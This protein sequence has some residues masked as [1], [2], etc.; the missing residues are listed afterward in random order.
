MEPLRES[1]HW[2]HTRRFG[3]VPV[4]CSQDLV[5]V[6]AASRNVRRGKGWP[7]HWRRQLAG[8]WG[9]FRRRLARRRRGRQPSTPDAG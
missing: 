1:A 9:A 2:T 8:W 7:A 4:V 5:R 6:L 3:G